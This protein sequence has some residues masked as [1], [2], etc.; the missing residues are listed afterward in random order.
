MGNRLK[1][2]TKLKIIINGF[3]KKIKAP[4]LSSDLDPIEMVW[5]DLKSY[6]R[7]KIC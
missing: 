6:V 5:S 4:A 2:K 1:K 7:K 3:I